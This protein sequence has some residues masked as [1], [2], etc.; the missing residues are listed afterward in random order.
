[1]IGM[2]TPVRQEEKHKTVAETFVLSQCE[3]MREC[4]RA[5]FYN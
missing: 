2:M 1:M 3:C 4:V 5:C